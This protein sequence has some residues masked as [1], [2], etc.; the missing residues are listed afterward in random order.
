MNK[1][2]N[3]KVFPVFA[4]LLVFISCSSTDEV[5]KV[6]VEPDYTIEDVKKEEIKR[7]EELAESDLVQAYWRSY[8]LKDQKTI[9]S[10]ADRVAQEFDKAVSEADYFKAKKLFDSLTYLGYEKKLS[11]T[12]EELTKLCLEKTSQFSGTVTEK[13]QRS[14][15]ISGTVTIWVDKGIRVENGVGFADRVIGSGFFIS[16]DGYIVT[17]HH[18][19]ADLVNPKYEGYARLYVKLAEDN[20]TR[21]PAKVIGW[22]SGVDLAV[23]KAEVEAPYV[24]TLGSSK[25]LEVGDK[26]YCIG[27]PMGLERTLTSGIVSARDRALFS[28][29]PVMQIDAAV[30]SGN[31]GGPCVDEDGNVQAIVFAGMLQ[32]SGL[33]FA[34]PVEYLK[35]E[36]PLLVN[37]GKFDHSWIQ[38]HGRTQRIG[39]KDLGVELNY[40]MPGGT[41]YRAGLR[42]GDLIVEIEGTTIKTLEDLQKKMLGISAGSIINIKYSRETESEPVKGSVLV[43]VGSRPLNPGFVFY[44]NDIIANCLTAVFGMKLIP[45]EGHRKYQ[46]ANVIKGSI[47]DETGFSENDPV[48]IRNITFNS[49]NTAIYAEIYAKNRKKGYLDISMG[50]SAPLD[51]PNYF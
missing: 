32:Y 34:I 6:F 44:R 39:G 7:I 31:S 48:D 11:L 51:G 24:F 40:V 15:Q 28:A 26:I 35:S 41:G 13:L 21:I 16:K 5:K 50:L 30:N 45:L 37:G 18:V 23:L 19:I 12:D 2:Y 1:I 38:A 29:G 42:A 49:D 8:L 9:N 33:N 20:E 27:S 22:D 14:Q 4:A 36:L 10:M 43:Y 25:N 3:K 17:N 47:A 46:I